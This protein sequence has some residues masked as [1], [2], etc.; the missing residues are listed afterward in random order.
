MTQF[1]QTRLTF[2]SALLLFLLLLGCGSGND[3]PFVTSNDWYSSIS[4]SSLSS[5][6][7][8]VGKGNNIS[9]YRTVNI[10]GQ[11]WMAENLNY[12]VSGSKCY[13]NATS[14]CDKYGRL[15]DW[16]TAMALPNYCY[17]NFC[18]SQ[19]GAKHRGICPSGWHIP[20]RAEWEALTTIVGGSS[21]D[22]RYLK[23]TNGWSNCSPSGSS[24]LCEDKFGF[25]ALPDGY[26]NSGGGFNDVGYGGYW[27]S[28]SESGAYGT[29]YR[30]MG[31]NF[32]NAY[33]GNYNKSYLFNVR[34]LQD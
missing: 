24:Y 27:W 1:S 4:S 26:G 10:G 5:S 30:Y 32:E 28:A 25:A 17:G 22:A 8:Y 20:T 2:K 23:A 9:N 31:Y 6:I 18:A 34:C 13:N 14:N 29:Y 15:Y 12:V 3:M 19:I 33:W 7:A 21:T 16:A 11:I